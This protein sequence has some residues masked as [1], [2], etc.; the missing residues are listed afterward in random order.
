METRQLHIVTGAFGYTGQ[1]I[2]R[3]LLA[4][5]QR[6]RTLTGH[7]DRPN[8]FGEQVQAA[9]FNFDDPLALVESLRG[10]DVLY[11]TY[12]VRF[13]HGTV[14]FDQAVENTR[15]L[16]RAAQEADV[17]RVVHVSIANPSLDSPLPYYHSKAL[18]EEAVRTSGLSYAI[19]R[20][21]VIFGPEDILINNMAW[22]VR[23]FPLFVVPG[24][25]QYGLQPI[26]VQ[27][28]AGLAVR[29]AQEDENIVLDA[30]G[31][32]SYTFDE[33]L[34]LIARTLG[35]RVRLLHLPPGVAL[36]LS[37]LVGLAVRDVVL[38][39][40]E[41]QGLMANLLVSHSPPTGETR[42][43]EWL[44]QNAEQVGSRYASEL[45]RHYT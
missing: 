2:T 39:R 29:V 22:L 16:I 28:M 11:N 45:K 35:R 34:R 20:P 44:R 26:F 14:T 30:V 25:G 18:L 4:L 7:P 41:V 15:T 10:A 19:L 13:S 38:T 21:T 23:R 33:L 27:D 17:R 8:P 40:E 5:G 12:W 37:R 32:E 6:V 31:P 43:S 42:L 24:D 36:L 3:R 1:Y 9:R